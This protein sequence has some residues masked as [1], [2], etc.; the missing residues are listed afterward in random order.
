MRLKNSSA[1]LVNAPRGSSGFQ[2][3]T[4]RRPADLDGL[5]DFRGALPCAF[6]SRTWAASIEAGRPLQTSAA[7]AFAIR[8]WRSRPMHREKSPAQIPRLAP[9]RLPLRRCRRDIRSPY[10]DSQSC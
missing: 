7:L 3:L 9:M 2:H 10:F 4:D 5:R 6:N 8:S 1:Q